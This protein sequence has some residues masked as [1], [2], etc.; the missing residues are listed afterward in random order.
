M[1]TKEFIEKIIR[2]NPDV[3]YT[4]PVTSSL[5]SGPGSV[6]ST[7]GEVTGQ[8]SAGTM[9][10][11]VDVDYAATGGSYYTSRDNES[12]IFDGVHLSSGS[13]YVT[14]SINGYYSMY[15]L[16][17][18]SS[19]PT[20]SATIRAITQVPGRGDDIYTYFAADNTLQTHTSGIYEWFYDV[21]AGKQF[22][23][24]YFDSY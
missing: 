12:H 6:N 8:A 4:G 5:F 18:G 15:Y 19:L 22:T 17:S 23:G 16:T 11:R 2:I 21:E 14:D 1:E 7:S 10:W 13:K 9:T 24:F 3:I 20:D